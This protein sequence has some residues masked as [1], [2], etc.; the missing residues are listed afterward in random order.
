MQL[1]LAPPQRRGLRA[2]EKAVTHHLQ[3]S[4][5]NQ[6]PLCRLGLCLLAPALALM[7]SLDPRCRFHRCQGLRGKSLR[8]LARLA[9]LP[10]QTLERCFHQ[11]IR[12]RVWVFAQA[13]C[14][15]DRRQPEAGGGQRPALLF[16]QVLQVTAD[17]GRSCR[18][19]RTPVLEAPAGEVVPA[20]YIGLSGVGRPSARLG[21]GT[22]VDC[23][24]PRLLE[25]D[26]CRTC[27]VV[28]ALQRPGFDQLEEPGRAPGH[29]G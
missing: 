11:G 24:R 1:H 26:L 28:I 4:Q 22:S 21:P 19:A 8:L 13:V 12:R 6:G 20:G 9:V 17:V 7:G 14:R 10:G 16:H 18:Q 3:E 2:P 15:C 25:N 27:S 23:R 29:E 5:V